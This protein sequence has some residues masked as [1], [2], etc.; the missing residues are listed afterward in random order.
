[1]PSQRAA[2]SPISSLSLL[3]DMGRALS[4]WTT[5][6][7]PGSKHTF[8]AG[9]P[10]KKYLLLLGRRGVLAISCAARALV[11]VSNPL[12][13]PLPSLYMTLR[14]FFPMN[15]F[16]SPRTELAHGFVGETFRYPGF[17]TNWRRD[18][19]FLIFVTLELEGGQAAVARRLLNLSFFSLCWSA[20]ASSI[21][22][23]MNLF[24]ERCRFLFLTDGLF[25]E[26][27]SIPPFLRR[28]SPRPQ[29]CRSSPPFFSPCEQGVPLG[30]WPRRLSFLLPPPSEAATDF[31]SHRSR[32]QRLATR[33]PLR[34]SY[35]FFAL[36]LFSFLS[37][38]LVD[39]ATTLPD[40]QFFFFLSYAA[41]R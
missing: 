10:P 14:G 27:R 8:P 32:V 36:P 21:S 1:L 17:G 2:E 38:G 9:S 40:G 30:V 25:L 41:W 5:P 23:N 22:G 12:R 31:L 29:Q 34:I 26:E 18:S 15:A 16:F 24:L 19:L 6:F 35:C 28:G 39:D 11:R 37:S 33:A 7:F 20:R 13:G 3:L 4:W